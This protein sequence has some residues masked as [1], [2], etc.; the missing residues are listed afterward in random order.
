MRG[1]RKEKLTEAADEVG[2]SQGAGGIGLAREEKKPRKRRERAEDW[3][4]AGGVK[5]GR[6]YLLGPVDQN[7]GRRALSKSYSTLT[8]AGLSGQ[9]RQWRRRR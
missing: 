8:V 4:K 7:H 6:I 1:A 2:E 3:K 9:N 5:L